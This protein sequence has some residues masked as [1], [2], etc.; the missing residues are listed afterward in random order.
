M[1]KHIIDEQIVEIQNKLNGRPKK[2][3]S[4]KTPAEIF[5]HTIS[6]SYVAV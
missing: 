3:L 1:F 4:H 6:K 5:F 2:N